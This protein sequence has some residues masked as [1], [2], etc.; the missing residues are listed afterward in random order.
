MTERELLRAIGEIDEKYIE[1]AAKE[2]RAAERLP[3]RWMNWRNA[4]AACRAETV[5][6]ASAALSGIPRAVR[7]RAW[8]LRRA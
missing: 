1:E 5:R 7:R 3:W 2:I 8:C 4:W 6:Q